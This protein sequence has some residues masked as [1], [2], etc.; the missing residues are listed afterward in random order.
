MDSLRMACNKKAP[1]AAC[2][3]C[4]STDGHWDQLAGKPFCPNCEESLAQGE[5]SPLV[6]RT[7]RNHCAVCNQIGTV[8]F[9]TFPLQMQTPVEIDLCSEHFRGLLGRRLGPHAYHQLRRQLRSLSLEVAQIFL[10]HEAFY[11]PQGRALQP[12]LVLE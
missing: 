11:D 1:L 4:G 7:E 9:L 2:C 10:L 5:G 6:E 3:R 12:A 8:R